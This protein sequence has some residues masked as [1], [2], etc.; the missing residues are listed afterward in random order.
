MS[1][2]VTV[3]I[4]VSAD[5]LDIVVLPSGK[6]QRINYDENSVNEL[7]K[8]ISSLD[9]YRIAVEATGGLE[10]MIV[11]ACSAAKLPIVVLNPRYVK[12]FAG[13]C[14]KLAKTDAIDAR[15][16]AEY[17]QS[18]STELRPLKDEEQVRFSAL[19]TRRRQI[20]A[21]I[22]SEKNRLST[23]HKTFVSAINKH[24]K[25]LDKSLSDID[26]EIKDFINKTP[27]WKESNSILQSV[28]GIGATTASILM[29]E[30]PELGKLNRQQ[31]AALVGLAP[32]NRDS[33]HLKGKRM[34]RGGRTQ[35]R[36]ALYMATLVASNH[37]P[38]I[39]LFYEKLCKAG[40]VFKVAIVACMR[41]LLTILNAMLKSNTPWRAYSTQIQTQN[42]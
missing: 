5:H 40:K 35:T 20:I 25:F 16:I 31:I 19:I 24:I 7:I 13:A 37:N 12:Q 29:A 38:V 1:D 15:T 22:V 28:P 26:S 23:A 2:K 17:L 4:D 9:S 6:H 41:K 33:G 34:I 36:N 8:F 10:H 27:L 14:S 18:I 39:K 21:M 42:T 30:L 11:A 32:Y 3:G